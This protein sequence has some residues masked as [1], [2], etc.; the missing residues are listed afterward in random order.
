LKTFAA[1]GRIA[2]YGQGSFGLLEGVNTGIKLNRSA[3]S[4]GSLHGSSDDVY[5]HSRTP[6]ERLQAVQ[7]NREVAYGQASAN[8]R[9]QTLFDVITR[10]QR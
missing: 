6:S 9:L 7:I 4:V 5:W 3:L 10:S 1:V 2:L 8:G